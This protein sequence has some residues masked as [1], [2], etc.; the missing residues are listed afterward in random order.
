MKSHTR[1]VV[2]GGGIMG[3]GLL[4]HLTKEGW[5]DVV[6]V[7]K[8]E[9]TSGSTWH[10]AAFVPHFMGNPG[11]AR[12]H[13]YA[14]EIYSRLEAETGQATGWHGCGT[15]RLGYNKDEMDW[16]RHVQG[17]LHSQG[18]E[19]HLIGPEEI[20]KLHPLMNVDGVKVGIYTPGDG[21]TDPAGSTNALAIGARAGGAEIYLRNRV[22][23]I[24]KR[25]D[26]S[27][28][29]ITEN[30]TIVAEHVV[31]ATGSFSPQV[32]AMV[33]AK[34]PV[35]SIPHHYLVTEKL[36]E[37]IAL[38]EEI[39][40]VRDPH[41][42]CYY[43]QEQQGLIVGPYE[44]EGAE[45][46][47]LNGVDWSFD[48]ELLP[49]NLDVLMPCL[50]AAGKRIPAFANAGIKRVVNG[51]ITH[52][53]DL[54]ILIGP[55]VGFQNF[56][57][58][59]GSSVGVTQGPGAGKYLAQWMVHGQAE[60]D[61]SAMDARR[62]GDW[63]VG[64]YA[65]EKSLN[66]Y[67]KMFQVQLPGEHRDAGRPVRTSPIYDRLKARGAR[68][69]EK[70]GWEVPN[71]FAP[72][73]M[74]ER[75]GFRRS[76]WFD[77]VA[78]ECKAVRER[79]G[80]M[81][82]SSLAKFEVSGADANA[83]LD[84]ILSSRLPEKGG[85]IINAYALTE[86]GGIECQFNVIRWGENC[87]HLHAAA[88]SQMRSLDWLTRY[89]QQFDNVTINDITNDYAVLALEGPRSGEVLA[90]LTDQGLENEAF[91]SMSAREIEIAGVPTRVLRVSNT[92][93]SGWELHHSM[94]H[95]ETLYDRLLG[96]GAEFDIADYGLYAANSLRMEKAYKAWGSDVITPT[97]A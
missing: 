29:V 1:V 75:Y 74:E 22:I 30:G 48:T 10:A 15:I 79:V 13:R 41:A 94:D 35:V 47:G 72:E 62:Y 23:D 83:F 19:C 63:A 12:I 44:M 78:A 54:G 57:L 53:P 93:E 59:C 32:G 27:W 88:A 71:W 87:Y 77:T 49:P 31:N 80:I 76:N 16:Y 85:D 28:D 84:W 14:S 82:R 46:W 92:G 65:V 95:M 97:T 73:G 68:F 60:I 8:G 11:M 70:F 51:P 4:Y 38:D 61:I 24:N 40:T 86:L 69:A 39:P 89:S 45:T 64:D 55:A 34:V 67:H 42:S 36:D 6:L 43:R 33:G 25:A 20:A 7:E 50:E 56:W 37:V 96:A 81:D 21:H 52:A 90:K 2:I 58:C 5:S 17:M 91:P 9:L 18:T 3:A 26:G 66:G